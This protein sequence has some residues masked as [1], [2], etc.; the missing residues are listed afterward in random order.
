MTSHN[1]QII[2]IPELTNLL[3]KSYSLWLDVSK[4]NN[5]ILRN[6]RI[7][8][9]NVSQFF[10]MIK[11]NENIKAPKLA[12]AIFYITE[13]YIDKDS[14]EN[15]KEND[16]EIYLDY[17]GSHIKN[18]GF[19]HF[20]MFCVATISKQYITKEQQNRKLVMGLSDQTGTRGQE[21]NIY[22]KMGCIIVG[23]ES[24][25]VCDVNTVMDKLNQFK[26]KYVNNGFF[27]DNITNIEM[28]NKTKNEINRLRIMSPKYYPGFK[29]MKIP[30]DFPENLSFIEIQKL[31]ENEKID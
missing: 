31:I 29:S 5:T 4:I 15:Y 2:N 27:V 1:W 22:T 9:K 23:D 8:D 19:G 28:T 20:L 6:G 26:E 16:K 18:K 11:S 13:E 25:L 12:F 30:K 21:N 17:L 7:L 24:D 14:F 3:P 10:I